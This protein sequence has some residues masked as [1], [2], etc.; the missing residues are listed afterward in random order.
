[1]NF[2]KRLLFSALLAALPGGPP[3]HAAEFEVLDRFSVDGYSVLKGSADI[4][5]GSFTVGGSTLVVK[6]GNVGIGTAN[7]SAGRLAVAGDDQIPG[8]IFST[9]STSGG[10]YTGIEMQYGGNPG[11]KIARIIGTIVSGGGGNLTF[12]TPTG[13]TANPYSSKMT[14]MRDGAVSVTS[15]GLTAVGDGIFGKNEAA[16]HSIQILTG[17]DNEPS[18]FLYP[19]SNYGFTVG[20]YIESGNRYFEV[21]SNN[22]SKQLVIGPNDTGNVGIGTTGPGEIL[23]IVKSLATT[24]TGIVGPN[25][26]TLQNTNAT[27]GNY[28]TIQNRDSSGGQNAQIQF[29]NITHNAPYQGALAFATRNA[30]GDYAERIRISPN[31][32]VGIGTANPEAILDVW[33]NSV[34]DGNAVMLTNRQASGG[35]ATQSVSIASRFDYTNSVGFG[36]GSKIVLGKDDV[37]DNNLTST[38]DSNIAFHTALNNSV[39]EKVRITSAGNVGIGTTNPQAR[40]NVQGGSFRLD[41]TEARFEFRGNTAV[42]NDAGTMYFYN[43]QSVDANK[44]V[45]YIGANQEDT[46]G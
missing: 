46:D 11:S 4:P 28:T 15:G 24:G 2:V 13:G 37:Y 1:M 12:E 7:P 9:P 32:N 25:G 30:I 38:V 33:K 45:A 17:S 18:L 41:N 6:N 35:V 26:L 40:L 44:E 23:H 27:A 21:R 20:N 29:I 22:G 8:A 16:N 10:G 43:S 3:V 5:G 39:E 14:I 31:G 36:N 42:G 19:S 34:T